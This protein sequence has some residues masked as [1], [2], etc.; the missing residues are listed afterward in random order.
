MLPT[1]EA[2]TCLMF[3]D[4]LNRT[5]LKLLTEENQEM[6]DTLNAHFRNISEVMEEFQQ[7]TKN[8]EEKT[9]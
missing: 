2:S 8:I 6:R 4:E 5:R 7:K 3:F 9:K 1:K